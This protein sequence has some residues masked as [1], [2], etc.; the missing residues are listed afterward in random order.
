M[1][2][3]RK[4][5]KKSNEQKAAMGPVVFLLYRGFWAGGW[6]TRG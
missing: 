4:Y 2:E 1:E 5:L 6:E 3:K